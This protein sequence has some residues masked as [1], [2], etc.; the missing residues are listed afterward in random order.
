MSYNLLQSNFYCTQCGNAN[1]PVYR[2]LSRMREAGHLKRLYC[3]HCKKE[4]N[5]AECRSI[6]KYSKTEFLIEF[7]NGNFDEEGNRKEDWKTFVN[8]W[9]I[10]HG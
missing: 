3:Y 9:R 2:K 8:N 7:N 6:G 1:I 10:N 5:H 4:T